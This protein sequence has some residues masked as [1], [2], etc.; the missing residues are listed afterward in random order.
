MGHSFPFNTLGLWVKIHY[1]NASFEQLCVANFVKDE[2]MSAPRNG[3]HG[4]EAEKAEVL[5]LHL[6]RR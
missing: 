2:V 5:K 4:H 6:S 1:F 3:F